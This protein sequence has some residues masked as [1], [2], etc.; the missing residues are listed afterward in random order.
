MIHREETNGVTV[1]RL[2]R[3]KVNAID[4]ELLEALIE[5]VDGL[6]EEPPSALVLTGGGGAFSA[7]VDLYRV[8]DAG[9]EYVD[10]FLPAIDRAVGRLF[11]FPAPTVAA[12]N[13]HAIAGGLVLA[14]ACDHRVAAGERAKLGLTELAV[15][16]PFPWLALE[17]ARFRMGERACREI[18]YSGRLILPAEALALGVVDAVVGEGE[19]VE[20]AVEV[21]ARLGAIPAAAFR[22]V[23]EQLQAP[24]LARREA[25][26]AAHS[27]RVLEIWKSEESRRAIQSFMERTVGPPKKASS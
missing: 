8:L 15:G 2:E 14:L 19:A 6:R 26:A 27:R 17:V 16:V 1:L 24:L 10:R 11:T 21:A 3:G 12:V 9:A 5:T 25:E 20:R 23:K 13:G 7:G 18:V 22:A 4:A